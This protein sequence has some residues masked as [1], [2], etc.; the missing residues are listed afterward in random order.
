MVPS[1]EMLDAYF[2]ELSHSDEANEMVWYWAGVAAYSHLSSPASEQW[3]HEHGF[4]T[5]EE[6]KQ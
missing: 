3:K 4:L 1:K 5:E 2:Y 6:E